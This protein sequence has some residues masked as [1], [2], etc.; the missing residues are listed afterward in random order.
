MLPFVVLGGILAASGTGPWGTGPAGAAAGAASG[1]TAP[2][3]LAT[4][5]NM[6]AGLA[7]ASAIVHVGPVRVEVLSPTLLRLE[8]SPTQHF[9]NSPTVNALDRRMP[10]PPYSVSTTGGWLTVRTDRAT[11]RYRLGSGPF[12][13]LNTSLRLSVAGQTSTVAPTWEWE[14][15]FGQVCQAGAATLSG[16]AT[17]SQTFT[18]YESTAGYAGFFVRVGASVTW[19]VLGSSAG[20]AAL[21]LR[22]A[23]T[24]SPPLT[25]ATSSLELE[26]NGRLMRTIQAAPTTTTQPWTTY[27]TTVPLVAGTNAISV[28]NTTPNSFDLG[29]DTLSIGPGGSSPPVQAST[30]PLGGWFRG[31][32]TDTYN[33]TP[34]CGPGQSG[35]TCE[36]VIQPL[37]TDG[38]LDTA[39]WRLLDDTQSDVWT[40]NGWVQPR[41]AHGDVED[42]YLFVYGH[43]YA[44]ALRTLAQLTGPAPLLPRDVFGVWYSD[45]TPYSSSDI[46]D[47]I[48][49]AFV[50]HQVPLNTLSLDTDWKSPNDWN[51]WE[52]NPLFVPLSLVIPPVGRVPQGID[53]TLNIHSSI[54]DNDPKLAKTERIAGHTLASSSCTNGNCK[55][56]DWSSIPQAESNFALQ[57]SFERQGVAFWWL[58]WCCDDSVVSSPGVT[59]DAW[60]DHLYAQSMT[61]LGERGF[62]L[63]RIGG[64]NGAPAAG[65]PGRA[66]VG[67]HL[68]DRL[69]R[70]RLGHL[71][72]AGD[73]GGPGAR[74]GDH[75]RALREQRHRELPRSAPHPVGFRS[76]RPLRPLGAARH[77]R[78]HPA[79][80]LQQRGPTP[81]A[82][83]PAG[84]GRSPNPSSACARSCCLT[85]TRSRRKPTG[86]VS[87]W[88]GPLYLDYPNEPSAY[89]NPTEYLYGPDML[90]AP[91]TTPGDVASTTVWFPPGRWVDFFTGATFTGP[92]SATLSVP[93]DQMPVFVRQGG[94]VP[95]ESATGG[96]GSPRSLTALVYPGSSGTFD[97]YGDA[98]TGLG[99]TKGQYTQTPITTA[100]KTGGTPAVSV[101][102]GAARGSYAGEPTAQST[103]VELMD[104]TRP[105]A[106][107][108]NGRR[109]TSGSGPGPGWSYQASTATLTVHVGRRPVDQAARV[110]ALGRA[111][112]P[113][114][115][116]TGAASGSS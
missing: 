25:P 3:N 42:G 71:E 75:R 74:R 28:V 9:E 72:H 26:V 114:N 78:A 79:A 97:L 113:S 40:T 81:L 22:Y 52:W 58:D 80:A 16:G 112:V 92:S 13:A 77:L 2:V 51:G 62:V 8:Y 106:V 4:P 111:A 57:T 15:T 5:I 30:G 89:E 1:D 102:I 7:H 84:A 85:P 54:E 31:F 60:I 41:P 90:V 23:N 69:H 38:L 49:P 91:V 76:P 43:D 34:T 109:L 93:L 66:V 88:P 20:P 6:G 46:E 39:G 107:M 12:T 21:S 33:D 94:I 61:N 86:P 68:R 105:A 100:T 98:G 45:Y 47:T 32:D 104:V 63:A 18:G 67:P 73:R 82:V 115:G 56:W 10:V 48:Y 35:A 64:S 87:R 55:V 103:T 116:A 53:V 108:L 50:S 27:T 110:V 14:C 99:Y 59:P 96:S 37:N 44:G 19:H 95:E 17:L 101:T 11:L 29:I 65:V 36:A 24:P 70:G 83:P